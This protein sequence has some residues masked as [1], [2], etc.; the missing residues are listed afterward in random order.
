LFDTCVGADR[1]R[2]HGGSYLDRREHAA[3]RFYVSLLGAVGALVGVPV[4][5]F[6]I[7]EAAPSGLLAG[8]ALIAVGVFLIT[9]GGPAAA[10]SKKASPGCPPVAR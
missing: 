5:I 6:L 9:R 10:P 2:C 8:G 3:G 4:A 7:G 1:K